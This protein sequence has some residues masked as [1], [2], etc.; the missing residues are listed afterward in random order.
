VEFAGYN[1]EVLI[2]N[3]PVSPSAHSY[4]MSLHDSIYSPFSV[5]ELAFSDPSGAY[6]EYGTFWQG[7]PIKINF[8][9]AGMKDLLAP[10]FRVVD[11][12]VIKSGETVPGL[13]GN[14]KVTAL[15][16][17]FFDNRKSPNIALK[18]MTVSDAVKKL[19]PA[20][21]VENTKGK[22]EAYAFDDPYTI[23]KEILLPQ[24][25]NGKLH[26]YCFFMD[27]LGDLHFKSTGVLEE[28]SPVETL[29]LRRI[30][31]QDENIYN[32]INSFLPFQENVQDVFG[33]L[34]LENKVL[35]DDLSFATDK[36]SISKDAKFKI[37]IMVD[38]WKQNS[39]Y[40]HRQF[41]PKVEYDAIQTGL[42]ADALRSGFFI[43]KVLVNIPFHPNL[44]A[45]KVVKT[46]ISMYDASYN[47]VLSET[48]SSNW[49]IEQS[50]HL[51]DGK[52][53]QAG[54]TL[55]LCRSSLKPRSDSLLNDKA[56]K[57]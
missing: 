11:R 26:P 16:K 17:S 55:V 2:N 56:F 34:Y 32:V 36:V 46:E 33:K 13:S 52:K 22:V 21:K 1:L 53:K 31:A 27:L 40:F 18:E 20:V 19:L 54:T 24:A 35:K 10:E 5:L 25:T 8:G 12:D 48:F 3:A 43:D 4:A 57:G 37:P 28:G 14:L 23:I 44:V 29:E 38:T 9:I 47:P 49:L 30:D 6:L 7:T 39:P 41:N 50:T 51:W 15:H 42:Q 45:G